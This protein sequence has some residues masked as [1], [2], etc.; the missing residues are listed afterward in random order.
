MPK[1]ALNMIAA[2]FVKLVLLAC[3]HIYKLGHEMGKM[4][5]LFQLN[6]IEFH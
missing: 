5:E 1:G 2:R 6:Q 3:N 4:H